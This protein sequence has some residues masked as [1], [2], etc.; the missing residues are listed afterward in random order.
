MTATPIPRSL[1]LTLYGDLDV[2]VLDEMPPGRAPIAHRGAAGGRA[3]GEV[4]R[5]LRRRWREGG[6][7]YV[8]FPLIEESD[9]EGDGRRLGR[10]DGGAGCAS[11]C[12]IVPPR[13]ARPAGPRRSAERAMRAFAAG[14]IRVLIATT[15]IEVGVD[16]P[17]PPG[18]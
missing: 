10:G 13:A 17:R 16:V 5:R 6:Q 11:T 2:S 1:A 18:W 3:R 7:A 15:V 4:Y 14:E 12:A 8:V 9:G